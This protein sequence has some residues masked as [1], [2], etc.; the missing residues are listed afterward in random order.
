MPDL[1]PSYPE[2]M[3]MG[4][5][6]LKEHN[7][8][9]VSYHWK[10]LKGLIFFFTG[11]CSAELGTFKSEPSYSTDLME[12]KP[13]EISIIMGEFCNSTII[14]SLAFV[15]SDGSKILKIDEAT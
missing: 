4:E 10:R 7:L 8:E 12:R 5:M 13:A 11:V 14:K 2:L 6:G 9:R 3:R 1:I 15:E